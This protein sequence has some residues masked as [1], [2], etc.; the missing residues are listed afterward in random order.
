MSHDYIA[1]LDQKLRDLS[2]MYELMAS[3]GRTLDLQYELDSFLMTILKRF[4]YSLGNIILPVH[5][6]TTDTS[7]DHEE[8]Y[9]A[10]ARGHLHSQGML[11]KR[12]SADDCYIT[13]INSTGK[14]LGHNDIS[15]PCPLLPV[16]ICDKVKDQLHLPITFDQKVIG[17]IQL[18][19]FSTDIASEKQVRMLTPLVERLGMT[20]NHLQMLNQLR[21]AEKRL[22]L[23]RDFNQTAFDSLND[24][25]VVIDSDTRKLVRWNAQVNKI[26][27]YSDKELAEGDFFTEGSDT[28]QYQGV[29]SLFDDHIGLLPENVLTT[30]DGRQIPFEISAS[31]FK[32]D[33]VDHNYILAVGRDI[34]ER[35]KAEKEKKALEEQLHQKYKMEA[36]GLMAGGIAHNFNNSLAIVLGNLQMAQ[37]KADNPE[38]VKAYVENAQTAVLRAR[39][40]VGQILVYSR[41]EVQQTAVISPV[42]VIEETLKLLHSTNPATISLTSTIPQDRSTIKIKADASRLHEILVNLYTN[43]VHAMNEKGEIHVTLSSVELKAADIPYQYDC[44]PGRYACISVQDSGCG[45]PPENMNRIFDPFFTTKEQNVGTGMGLSTVQGIV[46][47]HGGFINVISVVDHGSVFSIYFPLCA[48]TDE[49]ALPDDETRLGGT[50]RILCVDDD[51]NV[52]ELVSH[53]LADLGYQT[54]T[55]INSSKALTLIK[56]DPNYFD[57]ILSDQIMPELTGK[58]LAREIHAI[59]PQLPVILCTGYSS[60]LTASDVGR[61]SIRAI[62]AKPL[63]L[64][65]LAGVIRQIIDTPTAPQT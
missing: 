8:Y 59:N 61:N 63:Q 11:G 43:A 55:E 57:L 4:G 53:M 36:V 23:E 48:D 26:T 37:R 18:F 49:Q 14:H 1:N 21:E 7:S 3:I 50:E 46:K 56:Q 41:H 6:S 24:L 13:A 16:E 32:D 19:S 27:G 25:L 29:Q 22:R 28:L 65:E 20:I 62:C 15:R 34:S 58:E 51:A 42:E 35:K 30:K 9:I 38:R 45:M 2:V 64:Q 47:Q 60:E 52:V 54:T 10:S 5:F 39:E 33:Q 12:C 17:T 31:R 40:L 44:R